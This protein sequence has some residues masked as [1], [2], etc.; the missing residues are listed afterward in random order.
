MTV[1]TVERFNQGQS[2][3]LLG[4]YDRKFRFP[5]IQT[6]VYLGKNIAE[7]RSNSQEDVWYFQDP[8]YFLE[9]GSGVQSNVSEAKGIVL[10]TKETLEAYIDLSGLI[11]SLSSSPRSVG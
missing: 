2:Y 7:S 1:E 10:A 6:F 3:F 9:Q 11:G 5:Y 4:Y 8:K